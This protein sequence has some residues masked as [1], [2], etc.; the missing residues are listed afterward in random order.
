MIFCMGSER[1]EK[2]DNLAELTTDKTSKG[3]KPVEK[4]VLEYAVSILICVVMAV[5]IRN[6]VIT[7]ADV[8]GLSMSPTLKDKDVV[9]VEKISAISDKYNRGSIVI[10]DAHTIDNDIYIKRVIG[11]AGDQIQIRGGKV[12]LNGEELKEDYLSEGTVTGPGSF[13]TEG[14]IFTVPEGCIFVMGDNRGSSADSRSFGPVKL[15]DVKGRAIIR[16]FPIKTL[17]FL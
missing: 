2:V 12:Y 16:I 13:M 5:L 3:N 1:N 4:V 7:R 15:K 8:D 11:A 6:Y 14:R 9:F 10:F 17:K